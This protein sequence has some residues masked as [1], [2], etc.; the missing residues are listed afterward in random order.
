MKNIILTI[1]IIGLICAG[2]II[3]KTTHNT[4]VHSLKIGILQTASHPALDAARD[5][6]VDTI[7]AKLG[8]NVEFV[9]NNAQGSIVT[10]HTI[11]E[12]L[13]TD[14]SIAAIYAIATPALQA[15]ASVEKE[16]PIFIAAVSNPHQLSIINETTNICGTT[17]MIDI[18]GTI[19]AI[20]NIL[21]LVA[22]IALIYNPAES[23]SVTQIAAMEKQLHQH[24]IKTI[25]VSIATEMEIPQAI[26]SALSKAD[27]L[28]TPT[29]NLIASAMP[30]VAHLANS[31][32]KPLIACHNDA[33]KQGALMARGIDY[34]E[35]GKETGKIALAVLRD[36]KKPYNLP[37]TPTKSDTIVINK[38]VCD[39]LSI[40]IA[41]IS[42]TIMYIN[43]NE[44]GK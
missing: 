18:P 34:Y 30:L 15:I 10:A 36:G 37:I 20:K 39:E 13:H 4:N 16:K 33:V 32:H 40:T 25:R 8:N 43:S 12:R 7:K 42:D 14:D 3:K 26:A 35:S 28:L 41:E 1:I 27:A 9:I 29:D 11:A 22:T 23:N 31:A 6:F 44:Q 24:S 5:G 19:Q 21:P 38:Q 2:I 17:Y